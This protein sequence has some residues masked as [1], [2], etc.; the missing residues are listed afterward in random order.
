MP[1]F[2]V[3][4]RGNQA[5]R[6]GRDNGGGN[7]HFFGNR[8]YFAL[9]PF[10]YIVFA[11]LLLLIFPAFR[12]A[13]L[14]FRFNFPSMVAAFWGGT[15]VEAIY[16]AVLLGMIGL[17]FKRT[18]M[19]CLARY[20]DQKIL[21]LLIFVL[22]ASMIHLLGPWL[23]LMIAVDALAVAELMART[24]RG[25]ERALID[26]LLPA[27]YLFACL[28]IVST[29]NHAL[30]AIRYVGTYDAAFAHLDWVL[31]HLNV[32]EF[33]HWSL[34]HSPHWFIS[35]LEFTY[36]GLY[37]R[38]IGILLI[39][40]LLGN[41]Q[42]AL[43]YV[44]TI[45]ICYGIA[46]VVFAICPVK[47]PYFTCP[48]HLSSYPRNLISFWSQEAIAVKA[49]MLFAHQL[50]PDVAAVSFVDYYIGFPSMHTALPIIS[51]W[52]LRPWKRIA[53]VPLVIYVTVLLPSII[54]LEWHY[55][56]D[57][58]GGFAVAA[59][60]IWL[61]EKISRASATDDLSGSPSLRETG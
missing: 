30:A 53:L 29:F 26:I 16:F 31:F 52:F 20:H 19:P 51:I 45:F 11:I 9:L 27:T 13:H 47:G 61:S 36:F 21:F 37:G 50:T 38:L 18:L 33:A 15:V 46:M 12:L 1:E 54:I 6:P 4:G 8:P 2:L 14:P 59:L 58:F 3:G 25:F 56:V 40:A 22:G 49:R 28:I 41:R 35:L 32:S 34:A 60:A 44:R 5:P 48:V 7:W 55:L 42:Y 10:D 24:R 57:M 43:K 39:T 17:P 23:G